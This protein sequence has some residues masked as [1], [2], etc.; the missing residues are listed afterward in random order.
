[1]ALSKQSILEVNTPFIEAER[2]YNLDN[3]RALR[4]VFSYIQKNADIFVTLEETDLPDIPSN[5]S[6]LE[7]QAPLEVT[8][9]RKR[10]YFDTPTLLAYHNHIE[11]R[12]ELK[13]YGVKQVIKIGDD[14]RNGQPTLIRPEYPSKLSSQGVNLKGISD[15]HVRKAVKDVLKKQKMVPLITITS[16]R[17]RL[18][19]RPH[20]I[21]NVEIELGFDQLYGQ[22][23]DAYA[24][25]SF[26][27][28][29]EIKTGPTAPGEIDRILD[30]QEGL[31]FAP[32]NTEL[33]RELKSKP[34]PGYRYLK[35]TYPGKSLKKKLS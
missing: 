8:A 17:A 4:R 9:P 27:L 22:T 18:T 25:T 12:Q 10:V 6:N 28:E 31:I 20:N 2:K 13:T 23:F 30:Q 24:W 33:K 35:E 34:F 14:A 16:Q 19:Y 29:M 1:M 21:K 32:S 3:P 26:Q 7:F 5:I 11:I 15:K